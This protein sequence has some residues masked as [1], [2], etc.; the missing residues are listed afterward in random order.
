MC[1]LLFGGES[2]KSEADFVGQFNVLDQHGIIWEFLEN[3][4]EFQADDTTSDKHAT[5]CRE[6]SCS[7]LCTYLASHLN[8]LNY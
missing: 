2:Y 3:T 7:K 8:S 6:A 5:Y 4:H 1:G